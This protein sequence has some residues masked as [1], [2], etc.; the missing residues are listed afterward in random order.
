V[1]SFTVQSLSR[2]AA[3]ALASFSAAFYILVPRVTSHS[4]TWRACSGGPS[5]PLVHRVAWHPMTWLRVL[6]RSLRVGRGSNGMKPP[7]MFSPTQSEMTYDIPFPVGRHR[8]T[9]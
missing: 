8:L 1:H 2:F 4:M 9:L 6:Q 3:Y 5:A 7:P